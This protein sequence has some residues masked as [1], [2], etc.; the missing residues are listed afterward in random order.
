MSTLNVFLKQS[1]LCDQLL[2]IIG[3]N[4]YGFFR[5]KKV[6]SILNS[7][8]MNVPHGNCIYDISLFNFNN[9]SIDIKPIDS[10]K[11]I[12][13]QYPTSLT[14]YMIFERLC[15]EDLDI[16]FEEVCQKYKE[17]AKNIMPSEII[18]KYI[19]DN[20]ENCYAIHL[21]NTD[22][23]VDSNSQSPDETTTYEYDKILQ[24]LGK[25][26]INIFI[27]EQNP[28]FFICSEN[29]DIKNKIKKY[30]KN[31]YD[32]LRLNHNIIKNYNII[33]IN[34]NIISK[35]DSQLSNFYAVL[36]FFCL[37]KCKQ[38]I[39]TVKYTSFSM[40]PAIIGD[41][42][43]INFSKY[44]NTYDICHIHLWSSIININCSKND[45]NI[46]KHMSKDL[47]RFYISL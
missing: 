21:R 8:S 15:Q 36:D 23:I 5:N 22:K 13:Y 1:G 32:E 31:I 43:L 20:L 37:S 16:T 7:K 9:L 6:H 30:I 42:E 27:N 18:K 45:I 28:S 26:I 10:Y 17:I 44:L 33:E 4:V 34:N 40:L 35:E 3:L 14:P 29:K 11:E 2:P 25:Y 24:Y 19:P 12:I 41:I 46:Q 38:I 47:K 39:Q